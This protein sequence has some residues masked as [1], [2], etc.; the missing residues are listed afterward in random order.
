M[1]DSDLTIVSD[2]VVY[3]TCYGNLGRMV[4]VAIFFT[5]KSCLP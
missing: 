4:A 3:V 2:S 5:G 1:K